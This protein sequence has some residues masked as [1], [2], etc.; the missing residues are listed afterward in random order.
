MADDGGIRASD[1]DRENVVEILRDAYSTG[2]LTLE[3][4]D[5]RTTAAF[6]AR[7]WGGLRELTRDLPQQ[8]KLSLTRAEPLVPPGAGEKVPISA[9]QARRHFSPM[10]P[11]LV[12]WLSIALT[13]RA[14]DA[15]VP[16][17]VILLLLLRFAGRPG[18]GRHDDQHRH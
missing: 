10:L 3:E 18:R 16:V 11:I 13:A 7:T 1:S 15:F 4:F 9:G 2:R 17:I 8:A 6:A 14:P 12:I 5:E